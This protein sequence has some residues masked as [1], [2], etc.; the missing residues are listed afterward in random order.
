MTMVTVLAF[1]PGGHTGWAMWRAEKL[2]NDKG[3][4]EYY[5]EFTNSGCFEEKDH[6]EK[7]I[8]LIELQRTE[9]FHLITEAFLDRPGRQVATE[10]IAR[11]YIGA[12]SLWCQ[13]NDCRLI[14]QNAATAKGFISDKKLKAMG[15]WSPNRHSRDAMRHML[16]YMI[17]NLQMTHLVESWKGLV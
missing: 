4:P 17:T 14:K 12:M 15:Y 13:Q 11:D 7:L 5:N 8:A 3:V 2:V 1:D 10:L 9:V 16:Y 6:H